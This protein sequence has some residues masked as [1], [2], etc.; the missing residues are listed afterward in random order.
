MSEGSVLEIP[1]N[2]A[3]GMQANLKMLVCFV[4]LVTSV[5]VRIR[6]CGS[7]AHACLKY[8]GLLCY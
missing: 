7:D 8:P 2:V 5:G 6:G 1:L 4:S 3:C